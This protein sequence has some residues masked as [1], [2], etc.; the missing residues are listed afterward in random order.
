MDKDHA[1]G[2]MKTVVGNIKEAVGQLASDQKTIAEGQAEQKAGKAQ[3][4]MGS[5]KDTARGGRRDPRRAGDARTAATD[6]ARRLLH[7][8]ESDSGDPRLAHAE[9]VGGDGR[10]V[11]DAAV[12]ER[13]AIDDGHHHAAASVEIVDSHLRAK[14]QRGMCGDQAAVIGIMIKGRQAE[15]I[16][17]SSRECEGGRE[18]REN[19]ALQ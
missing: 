7:K 12:G 19:D 9:R 4:A 15:F 16:R 13:S 14:R 8:F 11:Y 3:N 6:L 2:A 10:D 1:A 18:R 17:Q 5:L